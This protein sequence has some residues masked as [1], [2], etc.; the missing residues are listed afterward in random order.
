MLGWL[1]RTIVGRFGYC[2]HL[3]TTIETCDVV[4]QSG[5]V[6]HAYDKHL[7]CSKCGDWK[8]VRL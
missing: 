8:R 2:T 7:Q 6:P 4:T 1:W 5:A 3:W